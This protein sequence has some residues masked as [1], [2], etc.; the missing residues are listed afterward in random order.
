MALS[1][2]M[3]KHSPYLVITFFFFAPLHL[4]LS[5]TLSCAFFL[6]ALC[7]SPAMCLDFIAVK[8][9]IYDWPL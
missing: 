9:Q 2:Y 6:L 3:L 7:Q 1:D 4:E 8:M 5:L